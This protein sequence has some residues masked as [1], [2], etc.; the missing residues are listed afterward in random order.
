MSSQ[1]TADLW[2]AS[3]VQAVRNTSSD[4]I[5][6]VV[7][8]RLLA[9]AQQACLN[10]NAGLTDKR[11]KFATCDTYANGPEQINESY[12]EFTIGKALGGLCEALPGE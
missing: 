7:P 11:I 8:S 2:Q 4:N 5:I 9:S 3:L 10:P 6:V 1:D 12:L